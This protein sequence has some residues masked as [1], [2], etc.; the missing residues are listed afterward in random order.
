MRILGKSKVLTSLFFEE[1][2]P[3]ERKG[4]NTSVRKNDF[5]IVRNCT[6]ES[7]KLASLCSVFPAEVM[8][9]PLENPSEAQRDA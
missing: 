3:N 1:N 8:N 4:G 5:G 9:D 6:S 7:E 2:A